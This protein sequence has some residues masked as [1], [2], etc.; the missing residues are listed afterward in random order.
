MCFF[1]LSEI[2]RYRVLA[3]LEVFLLL[4][5][6]EQWHFSMFQQIGYSCGA[7]NC[8]LCTSKNEFMPFCPGH[9]S[10]LAPSVHKK[11]FLSSGREYLQQSKRNEN[12]LYYFWFSFKKKKKKDFKNVLV[13]L[14]KMVLLLGWPEEPAFLCLH[15]TGAGESKGKWVMQGRIRGFK[16]CC[17]ICGSEVCCCIWKCW[18]AQLYNHRTATSKIH[19]R[20]RSTLKAAACINMWM[21]AVERCDTCPTWVCW[22]SLTGITRFAVG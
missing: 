4:F 6:T 9:S 1:F 10:E 17:F 7:A 15:P 5:K 20:G 3:L 19:S 16:Y 18:P 8:C 11:W 2:Q 22:R 21:R 13:P 12:F 14:S